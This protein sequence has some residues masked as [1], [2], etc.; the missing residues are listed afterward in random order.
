[1][2]IIISI[3]FILNIIFLAIITEVNSQVNIIDLDEIE[4]FTFHKD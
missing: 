3:E 1:M 4:V 2:I